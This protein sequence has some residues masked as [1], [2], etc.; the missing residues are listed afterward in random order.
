MSS[1]DDPAAIIAA[2]NAAR[3]LPEAERLQVLR[4][5]FRVVLRQTDPAEFLRRYHATEEAEA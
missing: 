1:T 2:V 3:Q 4:D 5:L